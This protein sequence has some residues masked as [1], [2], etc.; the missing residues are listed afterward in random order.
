MLPLARLLARSCRVYV[1]DLPGQ[2][3]SGAPRGPWGIGEMAVALGRWLDEAQVSRPLVVANS[4][5]CQVVTELAVRK[6]HALGPLVLVGP[7]MDPARRDARR[8][9]FSMLRDSARE[10]ASLLALAARGNARTDIRPLL[11]TARAALADRIEERLPLIAQPA[12][13]VYGEEDGFVGRQWVE[14][15]AELLP[16]GRLVAV[17]H[18]P[19]AVHYTRPALVADVVLDLLRPEPVALAV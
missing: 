19:H 10:P 1:P 9:A 12:V 8:Q 2:G 17:P 15:V 7:T 14:R 3:R 4:L 18:E 5:G 6:P 16:N 13:V 11:S